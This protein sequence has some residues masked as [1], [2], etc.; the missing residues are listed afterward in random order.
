MNCLGKSSIFLFGQ[1]WGCGKIRRVWEHF[2]NL[3]GENPST[4]FKFSAKAEIISAKRKF[5]AGLQKGVTAIA[6]NR[7]RQNSLKTMVSDSEL[8]L[9][10]KKVRESGLSQREFIMR[11]IAD[12]K[13]IADDDRKQ[14]AES[15]IRELNSLGN[16]VNQI[17]RKI[18]GGCIYDTADCIDLLNK[19]WEQLSAIRE[20]I[21]SWQ[22]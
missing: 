19:Y 15:I 22:F 13:I 2:G 3:A 14:L 12:K 20:V 6:A 4:P 16:N 10:K 5:A 9:T 17:A 21:A 18:N 8:A 11:C 1:T 7:K